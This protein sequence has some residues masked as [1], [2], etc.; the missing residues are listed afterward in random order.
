MSL[1]RTE[2]SQTMQ[3]ASAASLSAGEAN[4]VAFLGGSGNDTFAVQGNENI[5]AGEQGDDN[6]MLAGDFNLV[7]DDCGDNAIYS[8]GNNNTMVVQ[9]GNNIIYSEGNCNQI[10]ADCGNQTIESHG[11]NNLIEAG[12]GDHHIFF[13]GDVNDVNFGNGNSTVYFF[14][15]GNAIKGGNGNHTIKTL[16][17]L[18]EQGQFTEYADFVESY[19]NV[20]KQ[21]TL[22]QSINVDTEVT[23]VATGQ[24]GV[25]TA[26]F[27]D[28]SS[29]SSTQDVSVSTKAEYTSKTYTKS[30]LLN[31]LSS[32]EKAAAEKLDLTEQYN[33]KNRYVFAKG[34]DGKVHLYDKK[35]SSN[36][37]SYKCIVSVA[38]GSNYLHMRG[39]SPATTADGIAVCFKNEEIKETTTTTTKTTT[40]INTKAS[41][42]NYNDLVN[43]GETIMAKQTTKGTID[44]YQYDTIYDFGNVNNLIS[45]GDGTQSVYYTGSGGIEAGCQQANAKEAS[46]YVQRGGIQTTDYQTYN[47]TKK[48]VLY[49]VDNT[50]QAVQSVDDV[51]EKVSTTLFSQVSTGSPLIVDFNKDGKVSAQDGKGVDIDNNGTADGAATNGDKMLAMS[52]MNNNGKIDGSEV[53]G[54]QTVDPFTKQKINAA[55]GFEALKKV[56]ES[57]Y[58]TT[59]I[60]CMNGGNVDLQALKMALELVGV[61]LGFIS[62]NNV[63]NLEDL[64][65]VKSINVENYTQQN[66]TGNVQHNQLGS[67]TSAD[68]KTYKTDDVWFKLS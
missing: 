64:A 40:T 44:T 49:F 34:A 45:L 18:I 41:S 48:D 43:Y 12:N 13:T 23:N 53:F 28:E 3:L 67:Y 68:G 31:M 16:D 36:E 22:V 9:N 39:T 66:Q 47:N 65:H 38:Q 60:N 20:K 30:E 24:E 19:A 32:Q 56:A 37:T 33:G 2:I 50:K 4:Q 14:G 10:M 7:M 54:D 8:Q 26:G 29:S 5:I 46:T 57:A 62:D 35:G 25:G 27:K 6:V 59:G 61:K 1:L 58:K 63:T 21:E 55:N 52:D 17:W 11:N 51:Q 15:T 42:G